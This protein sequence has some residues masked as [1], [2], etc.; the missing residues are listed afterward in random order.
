MELVISVPTS[1]KT[2][3]FSVMFRRDQHGNEPS[4][5]IKDREFLEKLSD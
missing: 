1:H 4:G 5:Y 3:P 2:H